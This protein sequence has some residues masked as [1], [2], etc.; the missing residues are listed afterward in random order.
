MSHRENLID[1][2]YSYNRSINHLIA[3]ETTH[4]SLGKY[5]AKVY[6]LIITRA[7]QVRIR[8]RYKYLP[9]V[10]LVIAVRFL[11]SDLS[12]FF[13]RGD[14]LTSTCTRNKRKHLQSNQGMMVGDLLPL[15]KVHRSE[16][17]IEALAGPG[18]TVISAYYL[19]ESLLTFQS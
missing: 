1:L 12:S 9:S 11:D 10:F 5:L 19:L 16:L 3:V 14:P 7:N 18:R 17:I 4:L 8:K 13:K 2:D 15:S 6:S